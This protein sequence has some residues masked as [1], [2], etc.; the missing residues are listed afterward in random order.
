MNNRQA[1]PYSQQPSGQQPKKTGN[2]VD[3]IKKLE[4]NREDRR[5]KLEE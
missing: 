1:P 4:Q 3:N 2:V 5:K